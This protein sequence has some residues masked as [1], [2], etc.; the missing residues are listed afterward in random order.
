MK[1]ENNCGAENV[2][3]YI[4]KICLTGH[5]SADN[6]VKDLHAKKKQKLSPGSYKSVFGAPLCEKGGDNSKDKVRKPATLEVGGKVKEV[7]RF[8]KLLW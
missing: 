1:R 4:N 7:A 6:T 2:Q 3:N 5:S 8:G